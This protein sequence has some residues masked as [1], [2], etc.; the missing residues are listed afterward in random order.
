MTVSGDRHLRDGF[1]GRSITPPGQRIPPITIPR[2]A[3]SRSQSDPGLRSDTPLA[4]ALEPDKRDHQDRVN[5]HPHSLSNSQRYVCMAVPDFHLPPVLALRRRRVPMTNTQRLTSFGTRTPTAFLS[6]RVGY[7][8][9][10]GSFSRERTPTAFLISGRGWAT[11]PTPVSGC[12]VFHILKG[13]LIRQCRGPC[14]LRK[15]YEIEYDERYLW[16]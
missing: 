15:R 7:Q 16:D 14:P 11:G 6:S 8:T 1:A 2:V 3:P 5:D 10:F 12:Q 9:P 13:F 4:Y